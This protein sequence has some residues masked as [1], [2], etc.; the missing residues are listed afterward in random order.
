MPWELAK[1]KQWVRFV[2]MIMNGSFRK[3]E[4]SSRPGVYKDV[5]L[6]FARTHS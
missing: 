3:G 1:D 2:N 5:V 4:R 6:I